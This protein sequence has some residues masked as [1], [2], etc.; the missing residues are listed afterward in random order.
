MIA[1]HYLSGKYR[2]ILPLF[3]V[4]ISGI[5]H[6]QVAYELTRYTNSYSA[7]SVGGGATQ[8]STTGTNL[9]DFTTTGGVANADDGAA[10]ISL[11][12]SLNYCGT[13]YDPT[14][15]Y[16]NI[17][18]NGNACLLTGSV[19]NASKQVTGGNTVFYTTSAPNANIAPWWDDMALGTGSVLYKLNVS[20]SDSSFTIQ[21]TDILSYYTGSTRTINFQIVIYAGTHS[22]KPS[23]IEFNYGSISA[24]GGYTSESAS[25]GLK[26]ATGGNGNY[27][28]AVTGSK[29]LST[30]YLHTDNWPGNRSFRFAPN[31]SV[32]TLSA[33]TYTVGSGGN[34]PTLTEAIADVN[35]R[36]VSGAVTL[37]LTQ[38][39][40]SGST[41]GGEMFP[42]ALGPVGTSSNTITIQPASGRSTLSSTG[43]ASGALV[44]TQSGSAT[45]IFSTTSEPVLS[46]LGSDYVTIR[47]IDIAI[48]GTNNYLDYGIALRNYSATDGATNNT[49][50][51]FSV[52]LARAN[53]GSHG[54]HVGC[55]YTPTASSGTNSTNKLYN[56][57]ISNVYTGIR[58]DGS[59][60][61]TYP[62]TGN[63]IGTISGGTSYVGSASTSNDIGNGS[64]TG[65]GIYSQYGGV[66][67]FNT[68]IQNVTGTSTNS[69]YG[70]YILY[71][72]NGTKIYNNTIKNIS[73]T[74]TT[75]TTPV[76]YG[77]FFSTSSLTGT[78]TVEI[79]N[80]QIAN[81]SQGYAS[82]ASTAF[83]MYGI[84]LPTTSTAT[85]T[86]KVYFNSIGITG[87]ALS[88]STCLRVATATPVY[89]IKNN[90]LGNLTGSQST[91][92]HYCIY[93][94]VASGSFG[95]SGS[96][97]NY[98]CY[99]LANTTN[100]FVGYTSTTDR[101]AIS[102][103]ITA[104]SGTNANSVSGNPLFSSATNLAPTSNSSSLYQTGVT[105]SGYATDITGA[106]RGSSP[107]IGAYDAPG[108]YQA[109]TI[110][111]TAL[112]NKTTSNFTTSSFATI[113]DNNTVD[114]V[115]G[116]RPRLYYKK[117]TDNDAFVGNTSSDNG[118][119]WVEANGTTSPFDFTVNWGIINGGSVSLGNTIQY[120]VVA[121]DMATTPNISSSPASGFVGTT[122][123]NITST[124]WTPN[125]FTIVNAPLSGTYTIGA[126]GSYTSITSAFAD[127][128]TR[129][130]S[131]AVTFE[132]TD[133]TYN[134]TSGETFPITLGTVTGASASNT[135]TLKPATSVN[136]TII[137][138]NT[139]SA[140][141]R[142]NGTDYFTIDG[143]NN[144]SSTRNLTIQNNVNTATSAVVW[145]ASQGTA[146]GCTYVTIK[147]CNITLNPTISSNGTVGILLGG[148]TISTTG[149]GAD[150]DYVTIDNNTI[151]AC[152]Y[153]II[154]N[155]VATTGELNNL[156]IKNNLIGSTGTDIV[157]TRGI[158]IQ[159]TTTG[160]KIYGN[161]IFNLNVNW[162]ASAVT[163]AGIYIQGSTNNT[164]IYK[165]KIYD[166]INTT[167]ANSTAT[168]AIGIGTS[169]VTTTNS[170]SI[171]NN[172]IY[173]LKA[174]A[175]SVAATST[176]GTW[177]I[178]LYGGTSNKVY[179]NTV[180]LSGTVT[181]AAAT[182]L[183][184]S[185]CLL[186]GTTPTTALDVRNN[187][188][189]NTIELA[190]TGSNSYSIYYNFTT[191]FTGLTS[192]NNCLYG[193]N[194]ASNT[195]YNAGYYNS[196]AQTNF[197]TN[198][199]SVHNTASQETSSIG[200]NPNLNSTSNMIPLASSP[201][202]GA[203]TNISA[204]TT[205]YEGT[206]RN[207]STPYIGAYEKD[208]DFDAP[209]ISY[210]VLGNTGSTSNRTITATITDNA[211]G[212]PTSGSTA[213]RIWF[214][215]TVPSVSSWANTTGSLAT[216]NGTNGTWDFTINY[217]ALSI[218]PTAGETYQYYV[219]A[220]DQA[221]PPNMGYSPSSGASHS[222]VS[223]QTTAPTTPN[224]YNVVTPLATSLYVGATYTYTS[225]TGTGGLFEAI[226]NTS[227]GGNTTVFIRSNLSEDG[228]NAL[229][230]SG[231]NG[232]TLTIKAD[233]SQSPILISNSSDL[234]QSMIRLMGVS[235]VTLDGRYS[236]SG[237][238][239]RIIN[240]HA[241]AASCYAA[242]EIN[243]GS[244]S[245]TIRN[246]IFETNASTTSRGTI[247]IGTTGTNSGNTIKANII[248][249]A[250][251]TPGTAGVPG[252]A[253]YI[254]NSS[255]N[256]SQTIGGSAA[257]DGNDISNFTSVGIM[258]FSASDQTIQN[259]SVHHTSA[260]TTTTYQIRS[261]AGNN[262]T[263][264]D[265]KI[266]MD[267]GSS[268]AAFYGIYTVGSCN[269]VTISGNSIGGATSTRSGTALTI[270]GSVSFYGIYMTAGTTTA[271][272]IQGNT[273]GN[274]TTAYSI[275]GIYVAAGNVNIGTTTGNTIGGSAGDALTLT[276]SLDHST[277]H[278]ITTGTINF[279]NN[280][281]GNITYSGASNYR[282]GGL[283][284]ASTGTYVVKNNTIKDITSNSS[285]TTITSAYN[286]IG[287]YISSSI[288]AS[289]NVEGNT[290]YNIYNNNTGTAA[291]IAEGIRVAGSVASGATIKRNRI[292]NI[293]A[294]GT[295][296]GT[297]S[298]VVMGIYTSTGATTFANNQL[299]VGN[300]AGN[301]SRIYGIYL[302]G[303][304]SENFYYNSIV[305]NG[306]TASGTNKTYAFYRGSSSTSGTKNI[307]NNILFNM[308]TGGT[309][310]HVAIG[311]SSTTGWASITSNYNLL[312][313]GSSSTIGDYAGTVYSFANW[314]TTAGKDA[315]SVSEV[316]ANLSS[317]N[318]FSA[319][320][321]GNLNIQTGNVE[322]WY[323]N[324][325]GVQIT[326]QTEDYGSTSAGRSTTL[327]GGGTDI[328]ADEF[329]P[330]VNPPDVTVSGTHSTS[331]TETFTFA[332]R[333]VATITWG[334][335]GTL[336]TLS[337]Y[338]YWPGSW[339]N[340]LTNNGTATGATYTNAYW[341][342]NVSGGSGYTYDI[343]LYYDDAL[344]G[345]IATE[346]N[347]VVAKKA[348]GTAGTWGLRST[349]INTTSNTLTVSGLTSFSEFAGSE[350]ATPL[351]VEWLSFTGKNVLDN[352]ELNWTTASEKNNKEFVVERSSDMLN[353]ETAGVIKGK[354]NSNT[355]SDYRFTDVKP[356]NEVS[357]L[358][359]R[360][361]QVDF[362]G[363]FE[364]SSVI[365]VSKDK[366]GNGVT[367][368][369]IN[370]N[371][372]T[373]QL[374]VTLNHVSE[375]NVTIAVY[376]MS[377]KVLYT[378]TQI[379]GSGKLVIDLNE[380]S[381][382]PEGVYLLS[383][384]NGNETIRQKLV[385]VK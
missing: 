196:S 153:G 195:T 77:I 256:G 317:S 305:I 131:G 228:T 32:A 226:N 91:S 126:S 35:H 385:K 191:S 146:A 288:G 19:T 90:V 323:L 22:S 217:S 141:I 167:T 275:Y 341:V 81:L 334:S 129:G 267:G 257:S 113:T 43:W 376:D 227:L 143:S 269:N 320:S 265:N 255:N 103:L 243:N 261:D 185:A 149:T 164:E 236:G 94:S 343:T 327:A 289:S 337:S 292:Y 47:N 296:T 33:G 369:T 240:T 150:N 171:Y 351:P 338:K 2:R 73:S 279:E 367:I 361:K 12:F 80:N 82:T 280:T 138:A 299:T 48:S 95:A 181:H 382:L 7:I 349:T 225:L 319:T 356:F 231:L 302:N 170:L 309:G 352:V 253:I 186:I 358:Y 332:G 373:Q 114:T 342:I 208:G 214:R 61:T 377:G 70:I 350:N 106:T 157:F 121:Q 230:N 229:Q 285:N 101:T 168:A 56:F 1:L 250:Q 60:T 110:S 310:D 51:D 375:G 207:G 239:L 339:P 316:T 233:T 374:H 128:T 144:G 44:N 301:E 321:T 31:G 162:G 127:M 145:L 380:L 176:G 42:V 57:A 122:V 123:S 3:L 159:N 311:T 340:D 41:T 297:S 88:N 89:D 112:G 65:Y 363:D 209:V 102:D 133:A 345:T 86:F 294:D 71:P 333:T 30:Y 39:S 383:V 53:T 178:R 165:N 232:Y 201:V 331:G 9:G 314:Q 212:V 4:L 140:I 5:V 96:V 218:T 119:K 78:N 40:Y 291:Y 254:G 247:V 105:I 24:T 177:G 348:T 344:L 142:L 151:K 281:I 156:E 98:N 109:P 219:V 223:S 93:T 260:R 203:G 152:G 273:V 324:G 137:G 205:D 38:S 366:V 111:Y 213:P 202:A 315:N 161:E 10:I 306:T 197:T 372:F 258:N 336:P 124:P 52:T 224:S 246:C 252:V 120:F 353:F 249:D 211:T 245:N 282:T 36:G 198:W 79:Y 193:V 328:G 326:G 329:T 21:W 29:N 364:Y 18:T 125:S 266:Y 179:Y 115:S 347:M 192:N 49:I 99:Y 251:G 54:V 384:T 184:M 215:R 166:I 67:I 238:N 16:L 69:V 216:G 312:V 381:S 318:L 74:Y 259:N 13:F 190:Y 276:G 46:L 132:L 204:V 270:S 234:S 107:S 68:T 147:N 283:D 237:T 26:N 59:T 222:S 27:L 379:T 293:K 284:L 262:H 37:S 330:S 172:L 303:T 274:I 235:G 241:T 370:P 118:W 154:A 286:P 210:T 83:T 8:I 130:I 87:N 50:R 134:T 287:I 148:T 300:G 290:I 242:L 298:P 20:G 355:P 371:P 63:E 92:K 272:S 307:Q 14:T 174:H 11:P 248:R 277:V 322:C 357:T 188:F 200:T 187:V 28:D 268:S 72:G 189:V 64:T 97:M 354:G 23:Y 108:D 104:Y 17:C 173:N 6:A 278:L 295:G 163:M 158:D 220:Q 85:T 308:R 116:T 25:I 325:R 62:A 15:S 58:F 271:G 346:A 34:Y 117:S 263:I 45:T 66:Q 368:E 360:I 221:T 75:S 199:Q 365:A 76:V 160:S 313:S 304:G 155:G 244:T 136:A 84:Y 183:S 139:G 206:T 55:T 100:G 359:Y 264:S 194:G 182:A 362:N 335:G 135:V 180:Y 175:T 378:H 169:L